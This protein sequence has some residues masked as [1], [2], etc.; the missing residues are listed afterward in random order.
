M[1]KKPIIVVNC[2]IPYAHVAALCLLIVMGSL[3]TGEATNATNVIATAGDDHNVV[4]VKVGVV[5][6]MGVW[7]GKMGLSCIN[8]ALSEFYASRPHYRTRLVVDARDSKG[9]V[10]TAAAAVLDLIENNRVK[11]IIGPTTS[12]EAQFVI[13]LGEKAH[14]PIVTYSATS[15]LLA[16][17]GS[18]YF[19]QATQDDSSQVQAITALIQVFGWREVVP[20]YEDNEFGSGP[21]PFLED[22]LQRN[23]DRVP[24]RAVIHSSATDD[25]ISAELYKLMTMQ[26]RVFV[27]H[28][29]SALGARLIST[30]A[31]LG[32]M[33]QDY[34]WI[35]TTALANVL[36]TLDPDI[37]SSMQGVLGVKSYVPSTPVLRNFTIHWQRQFVHDNPTVLNPQLDVFGLWAYD[38]TSA[39]ARAIE[40]VHIKTLVTHDEANSSISSTDLSKIGVSQGGPE[41]LEAILSTGFRGLSCNFSLINRQLDPTV[42][43]F[44]NVIGRGEKE[45]GFWT[46]DRGIVRHLNSGD[47]KTGAYSTLKANLGAIIWPGD[48]KFVPKG[49]VI[50]TSG[51][52]LLIGVPVKN[53][54]PQFVTVT[55]DP[56]TNSTSVTGYCIDVFEAVIAMLPYSVPFEYAPFQKSDGEMAGTYDDLID[57][58]YLKKYDAVVGDTTIIANRSLYVD[59]TL[60]YTESGVTMLVPV[61]GNNKRNA[62]IFLRPL[63]SGLWITSFL[64]FG[65]IAFVIWL[66]EHRISPQFRGPPQ[67]QVGYSLFYSFSTMVFSHGHHVS[68]NLTRFVVII[69]IFL[70][71]ILTQS[72]TASLT[73]MLTVD[74]LHPAVT[75]MNDLIKQKAYVGYQG[76]SFVL[77]FLKQ[78]GFE[79]SRL[80]TYNSSDDLHELLI[81]G[82]EN[83]GIAAAFDEIPYLKLF[84]ASSCSKYTTVPPTYKTDGFGFVFPISSPLVSDISRAILNVTEG[85]K[86]VEIENAWFSQQEN[87][88]D[89]GAS[90][91]STSLG[92]DSF[93]GLFMITGLAAVL[94]LIA[95][96]TRF[97]YEHRSSWLHAD[98]NK[99]FWSRT[100]ELLKIFDQPDLNSHTS[101]RTDVHDASVALNSPHAPDPQTPSSYFGANSPR[102]RCHPSPS[103]HGSWSTPLQERA[104]SSTTQRHSGQE[105]DIEMPNLNLSMP[106]QEH[107]NSS[108]TQRRSGQ[109]VVLEMPNLNQER[110]VP[111]EITMIV[112]SEP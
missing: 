67:N 58:V 48:S 59:F 41:L 39:I 50:P 34:V 1:K 83:G 72:Y 53:G 25:H 5:G 90:D 19:I 103:S 17:S 84:L 12:S 75:D 98:P 35:I 74:Q 33:S 23:G 102:T 88:S 3:E 51:K 54:F 60:P 31:L 99:S 29:T 112:V 4:E 14:V 104:N 43:Q 92:L 97:L 45:I 32:M 66:L 89:S 6:D 91:S 30:A 73:S 93:W 2:H 106:L 76:G 49:W 9:D 85:N 26:T 70:L 110:P 82:S 96:I 101:R 107:V 47:T 16:S 42:F 81:K 80:R 78:M 21:I 68:N 11:A 77:G 36:N 57:Q 64:F 71:L 27:V 28:M 69:W 86:M 79:E 105:V 62:W 10:V 108:T 37:V 46:K 8:M 40:H 7:V 109:Q 87:C 13:N 52:K 56:S 61:R 100:K 38:A 94:A 24:Y 20:I 55:K 111:S 44:I 65:F 15:P 63:S 22:A 18:P 95:F